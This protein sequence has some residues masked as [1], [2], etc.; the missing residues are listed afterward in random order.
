MNLTWNTQDHHKD[1]CSDLYTGEIPIDLA[2]KTLMLHRFRYCRQ[3]VI[4]ACIN[5]PSRTH[6]SDLAKNTCVCKSS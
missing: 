2:E 3:F 5:H 6:D 1:H 4:K